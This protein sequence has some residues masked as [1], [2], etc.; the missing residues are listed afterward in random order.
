MKTYLDSSALVKLYVPEKESAALSQW[1]CGKS[2]S[3]T[4]FHENIEAQTDST[5]PRRA[6]KDAEVD[7]R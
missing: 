3:F 6:L 7:S 4:P 5:I 1:V 2:I